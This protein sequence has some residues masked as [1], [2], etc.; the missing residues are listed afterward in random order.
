[1]NSKSS[2]RD[3]EFSVCV[4]TVPGPQ[5]SS[6]YFGFNVP[7]GWDYLQLNLSTLKSLNPGVK[8]RVIV[9]SLQEWQDEGRVTDLRAL[10]LDVI[11]A[12]IRRADLGTTLSDHPSVQHGLLLDLAKSKVG[13]TDEYLLVLDPDCFLIQKHG[14]TVLRERLRQQDAQVI[15]VTYPPRY[16]PQFQRDFPVAYL[17]LFHPRSGWRCIPFSPL[18]EDGQLPP[19]L[20]P[21]EQGRL[22]SFLSRRLSYFNRVLLSLALRFEKRYETSRLSGHLRLAWFLRLPS[23]LRGIGTAMVKDTGWRFTEFFSGRA[24]TLS[25]VVFGPPKK[26]RVTKDSLPKVEKHAS[27]ADIDDSWMFWNFDLF[28]RHQMNRRMGFDDLLLRIANRKAS[29]GKDESTTCSGNLSLASSFAGSAEYPLLVSSTIEADWYSLD[30]RIIALHLG[31]TNK[32]SASFRFGELS[33]L[34]EKIKERD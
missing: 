32:S 13:D 4:V 18:M 8:F 6:D 33:S 25:S 10:G 9:A 34:L 24:V 17:Q 7:G 29:V 16:G 28:S 30:G 12:V 26:I 5:S 21:T 20:N 14:L 15:G 11:H 1:M 22:S 23:R 27:V 31:S 3:N 2:R 19:G